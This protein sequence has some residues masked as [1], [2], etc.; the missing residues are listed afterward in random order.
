MLS[1]MTSKIHIQAMSISGL[2]ASSNQ[3]AKWYWL[4]SIYQNI[5]IFFHPQYSKGSNNN[6]VCVLWMDQQHIHITHR[7][8]KSKEIP[9]IS[10]ITWCVLFSLTLSLSCS[11]A[12]IVRC[13]VCIYLD[14]QTSV[15]GRTLAWKIKLNFCVLYNVYSIYGPIFCT[16]IS[17][18]MRCVKF[19]SV[20]FYRRDN[21]TY[22]YHRNGNNN[23]NND[24]ID[25]QRGFPSVDPSLISAQP[26]PSHHHHY[27][28]E[29]GR[30]MCLI[31]LRC[32]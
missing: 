18:Q 20:L 32:V 8:D 11:R 4:N 22:M 16:H 28:V 15:C 24:H 30:I 31:L 1:S 5:W 10:S 26:W 19:H 12:S 9:I 14:R 25:R 2:F 23:S 6:V 7:K 13:C 29:L 17:I 27:N 21:F 3:N